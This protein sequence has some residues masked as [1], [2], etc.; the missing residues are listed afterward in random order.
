MNPFQKSVYLQLLHLSQT[1]RKYSKAQSP[2]SGL[3][4]QRETK[5]NFTKT[6]QRWQQNQKSNRSLQQI[7][8]I[9]ED[10]IKLK[11]S[12]SKDLHSL[13]NIGT[14]TEIGQAK[15]KKKRHMTNYSIIKYISGFG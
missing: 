6:F 15:Y 5:A 11:P 12:L 13:K 7:Q 2:L 14:L 8:K 9:K 10:Q 4:T 3:Q 1:E